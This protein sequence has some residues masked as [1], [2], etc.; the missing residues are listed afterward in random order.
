M[1]YFKSS[2]LLSPLENKLLALY[3]DCSVSPITFLILKSLNS[4]LCGGC[5]VSM[6]MSA[7]ILGSLCYSLSKFVFSDPWR[8]LHNVEV[9]NKSG[10][11]H[12]QLV[13]SDCEGEVDG[14][15][16]FCKAPL[17]IQD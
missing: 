17:T 2:F 13:T 12:I 6:L 15:G 11:P 14:V 3:L 9:N 1:F 5:P 8:V 7:L 4:T 10:E 16:D